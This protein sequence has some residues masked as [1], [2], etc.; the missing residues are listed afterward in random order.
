VLEEPV[1]QRR[2]E[3]PPRR[4]PGRAIAYVLLAG[5]VAAVLAFALGSSGGSGKV[6]I[7]NVDG[8]STSEVVDQMD[9]LI[10]DNTR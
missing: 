6:N 3:E 1:R 9:Q 4:G 5:L 10:D 2:R 8:S 7:T